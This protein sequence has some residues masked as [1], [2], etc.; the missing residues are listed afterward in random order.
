MDIVSILPITIYIDPLPHHLGWASNVDWF[1][2]Y[3]LLALVAPLLLEGIDLLGSPLLI[4]LFGT[5]SCLVLYFLYFSSSLCTPVHVHRLCIT[6]YCKYCLYHHLPSQQ[7]SFI[8]I[9][10]I[11]DK[12]LSFYD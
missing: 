11:K 7:I 12:L 8:F 5:S 3:V 1:L 2:G 6:L 9:I 4:L 10:I